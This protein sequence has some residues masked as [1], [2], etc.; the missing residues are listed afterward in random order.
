MRIIHGKVRYVN[1]LYCK[2]EKM[3]ASGKNGVQNKIVLYPNSCN[4]D[5]CCNEVDLYVEKSKT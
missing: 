1:F 2:K 5:P 4:I 3:E